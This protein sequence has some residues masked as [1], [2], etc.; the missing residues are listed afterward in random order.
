MRALLI[1]L[2]LLLPI[3]A[4]ASIQTNL[5]RLAA[6]SEG[7]VGDAAWGTRGKWCEL[8][9]TTPGGNAETIAVLDHSA[10]A[11]QTQPRRVRQRNRLLHG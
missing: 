3:A 8:S 2:M 6:T 11:R 9:A 5:E 4:N 10:A 7:K 1:A